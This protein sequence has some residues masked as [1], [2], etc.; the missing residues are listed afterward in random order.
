MAAVFA[1]LVSM[2]IFCGTSWRLVARSKNRQAQPNLE[3]AI[4]V[5]S[6]THAAGQHC[7][8][9]RLA[10]GRAAQPIGNNDL[11][12]ATHPR[13]EGWVLVTNSE[14]EFRRVDGLTAEN[15]GT[16]E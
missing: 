12:V 4:Q 15:W 13:A 7:G 16:P 9:I 10:L 11:W 6:L 3:S 2:V 1:P 14:R 5:T 8:L